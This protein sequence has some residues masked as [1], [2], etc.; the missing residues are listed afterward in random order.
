MLIFNEK[1]QEFL[2][3]DAESKNFNETLNNQIK[4]LEE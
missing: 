2:Q 3:R 1:T 4:D